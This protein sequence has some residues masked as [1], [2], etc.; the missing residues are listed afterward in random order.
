MRKKSSSSSVQSPTFIGQDNNCITPESFNRAKIMELFGVAGPQECLEID[1][2]LGRPSQFEGS[3]HENSCD[4]DRP[5]DS[6]KAVALPL[7]HYHTNATCM[8]VI[9]ANVPHVKLRKA[10]AQP[11]VGKTAVVQG[12][13]ISN[14]SLKLRKFHCLSD[15]PLMLECANWPVK[16][17]LLHPQGSK[18]TH[19]GSARQEGTSLLPPPC[20]EKHYL[21]TPLKKK[22]LPIAHPLPQPPS[23]SRSPSNQQAA[24]IQVSDKDD[25]VFKQTSSC[26]LPTGS[27]SK[28]QE[29]MPLPHSMANRCVYGRTPHTSSLETQNQQFTVTSSPQSSARQSP[30]PSHLTGLIPNSPMRSPA[31]KSLC[32]RT[33]RK[34]AVLGQ[35]SFGI[36][37]E[38]LNL[39]DGSFFAVKVSSTADTSPEIQQE[40]DVLSKLEHPNIVRYLGSSIEDGCL[41]IF[42]ELVRMGSLEAILRKYRRFEDN[43]IRSYTRQILLGLE[44]LHAKKTIHRDIKC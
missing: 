33:W 25:M 18:H 17:S 40:V 32:P 31:S 30:K 19:N 9:D 6:V 27:T 35:G 3:A 22:D 26:G 37:H 14:W 28:I 21:P 24:Q 34:G 16:S 2:L 38:G 39:E 20:P 41:C 23:L 15:L 13:A 44:Y 11:P 42:I 7:P 8:N 1:V 10:Y 12:H 29:V 36:V 5:D 43:T 4:E